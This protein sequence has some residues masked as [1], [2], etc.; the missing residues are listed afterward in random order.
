[1][2]ILGQMTPR[3]VLCVDVMADMQLMTTGNRIGHDDGMERTHGGTEGCL[4]MGETPRVDGNEREEGK[5]EPMLCGQK[6]ERDRGK[7]ISCVK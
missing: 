1:M 7:V 2:I 3:E 5:S 6:T 4:S